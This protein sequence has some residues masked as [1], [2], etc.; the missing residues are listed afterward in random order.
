MF[1]LVFEF[2]SNY[3]RISLFKITLCKDSKQ[4]NSNKL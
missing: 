1:T 4:F 3:R 2:G